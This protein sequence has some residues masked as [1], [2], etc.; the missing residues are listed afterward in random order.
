MQWTYSKGLCQCRTS[1]SLADGNQIHDAWIMGDDFTS[2]RIATLQM[3]NKEQERANR[4]L[5]YLYDQYNVHLSLQNSFLNNDYVLSWL[6]NGVIHSINTRNRIPKLIVL[7]VD[8]NLLKLSH[9]ADRAIAWLYHQIE[10]AFLARRDQLP[11]KAIPDWILPNVIA[12]KPVTRPRWTHQYEDFKLQ[13]RKIMRAMQNQ[14]MEMELFYTLHIDSIK[15]SDES[16]FDLKVVINGR[17]YAEFWQYLCDEV[18]SFDREQAD[19]KLKESQRNK[20]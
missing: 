1:K 4:R 11:P 15:P 16:Y 9:M 10:R 2:S 20:A 19:G 12:V 8:H 3:M 17:G 7:I 13:R 5:L 6:L 14:S 18:R